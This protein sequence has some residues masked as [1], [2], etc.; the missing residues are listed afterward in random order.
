MRSEVSR[1]ELAGPEG[2]TQRVRAAEAD[3][4]A[5]GRITGALDYAEA[6]IPEVRGA[7]LI[8]VAKPKA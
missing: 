2:W 7:E 1:I 4:R 8:P 3:L 6:E 5:A